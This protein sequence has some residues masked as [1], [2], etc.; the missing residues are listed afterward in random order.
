[1]QLLLLLLPLLSFAST[2]RDAVNRY[3]QGVYEDYT[4]A[5]QT[6]EELRRQIGLFT[7]APSPESHAAAKQAWLAARAAYSPT[8][9]YRFYQGPIDGE[10]G[11]EGLLNAWPLDEAYID[12]VEGNLNAGIINDSVRYPEITK[13]LLL[14]LNEKDG[15]TNISTGY[16]AIEFLLWGQDFSSEGPG[17]R[18]YRDFIPA[19]RA[20]ADRRAAYLNAAADLLVDHLSFLQ[21]AW[22]P[23]A[24]NYRATFTNDDSLKSIF[25]GAYRLAGEEL[26]HERM[27]VAYDTGAQEDEHSCFSDNT[28]NDIRDNFLGIKKV[29]SEGPLAL[30]AAANSSAAAR[31]EAALMDAEKAIHAIPAPFDQAI[32]KDREKILAAVTAL[33]DLAAATKDAAAALGI[34]LD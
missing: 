30:V 21:A 6:G 33:E 23:G 10:D 4:A 28:H 1:M 19:F 15:E 3:A 26:S 24:D 22:A 25:L 8:E 14:S 9:V 31:V 7:L 16:H 5:K 29:L 17:N 18:D 27:Y 13:E 32:S 34:T 20:N 2:P 11:P 12:F